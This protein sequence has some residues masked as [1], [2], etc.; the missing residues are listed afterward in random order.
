MSKWS[1]FRLDPC[2]YFFDSPLGGALKPGN[3]RY[4]NGR[5]A[6]ALIRFTADP[7]EFMRSSRY[8]LVRRMGEVLDARA[9]AFRLRM[10][11]RRGNP[12]VSVIMPAY[13][14]EK[15]IAQSILSVINQSYRNW[16]LIVVDD[17]STDNTPQIVQKLAHDNS[18]IQLVSTGRNQGAAK[19]R[20]V[21]IKQAIGEFVAFWDSDDICTYRRLERQLHWLLKKR[22]RIAVVCAYARVDEQ[23]NI[24][25]INNKVYRRCLASLMYE[26]K[27]VIRAI[28]YIANI[29]IGED[30]DYIERMKARFGQEAVGF[31]PLPLYFARFSEKSLLHRHCEIKKITSREYCVDCN[32]QI[33]GLEALRELRRTAMLRNCWLYVDSA[34]VPRFVAG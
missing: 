2:G 1:K 22:S 26:R 23:G 25:V 19:A 5:C 14:A 28:G 7:V 29:P 4:C 15:T 27:P 21:G 30:T 33:I 11:C 12:L 24:V 3:E 9:S 6:I 17:G 16:E 10:I 31:L 8:R 34:G 32:D 13:N 20:N 18:R